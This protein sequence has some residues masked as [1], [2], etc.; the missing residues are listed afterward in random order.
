MNIFQTSAI[1]ICVVAASMAAPVHAQQW[2]G[3]WNT[4]YG[5]LRLAQD[6]DHLFGDYR[7][8]TIEGIVDRATGRA[9]TIFRNPD[10]ST[11]YAE[12]KLVRDGSFSGAFDWEN[13]P[14][15]R[16]DAGPANRKW[17][18]SRT[19]TT[20]PPITRFKLPANRS[21][22]INGAPAKYRQ[23]I[24]GFSMAID[25][26]AAAPTPTP[27]ASA[28]ARNPLAAK[29]PK[30]ADYPASFVPK[31]IEVQVDR[32]GYYV[33]GLGVFRPDSLWAADVYGTYG[34]Y[35]YCE[36]PAGTRQISPL[37]GQANRVFDRSRNQAVSVGGSGEHSNV[38]VDINQATR[39]FPF[40]TACINT[41]GG[42]IAIQLQTNLN[43]RNA[44]EARDTKL[45][46]RGFKFY[47]DQLPLLNTRTFVSSS[48]SQALNIWSHFTNPEIS[49]IYTQATQNRRS[50]GVRGTI[51]FL[52]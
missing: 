33:G 3:A 17:T 31:T 8:G 38:A 25:A 34:V 14:L 7:D 29:I 49:E 16:H 10:G 27:A 1:A 9:R 46:Y 36:T 44:I 19:A 51:R 12:F 42:R 5:Q 21:A 6:G 11:G 37:A 2:Q 26:P 28:S 40:D 32:L 52:P 20:V 39:R 4:T 30:L 23:W 13:Q 50:I 18:G 15:P 48:S 41:P 47:L 45:G 22:F 43:E 35:A 24:N